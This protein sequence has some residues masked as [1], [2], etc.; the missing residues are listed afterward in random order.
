LTQFFE[1]TQGMMMVGA[2]AGAFGVVI[3]LLLAFMPIWAKTIRAERRKQDRDARYLAMRTVLALDDFVGGCY[4][5]AHDNPE[6][7]PVDP[8][9]FIFHT[10]DPVLVLPKDAD[11]TILKPELIDDILWMPNRA[12]NVMDA[13]ESLDVSPPDFDNYFEHRQEGFARLGLRALDLIDKLCAVY[14]LMP[15]ERPAY[16]HPREGLQAKVAQ[17]TA[18]WGRRRQAQ[19][20]LPAEPSNITPLFGSGREETTVRLPEIDPKG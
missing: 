2:I 1:S 10:D 20:N 12:R 18:L 8:G 4:S 15:P 13:L 14:G 16:Y 11:W 19:R 3:G 5:A 9:D 6:F 17:M 7:N